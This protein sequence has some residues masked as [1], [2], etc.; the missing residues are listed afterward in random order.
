MG[1][2]VFAREVYV[3]IGETRMT[4]LKYNLPAS[5][6]SNR[7]EPAELKENSYSLLIQKQSGSGELPVKIE[8]KKPDGSVREIEDVLTGDKEFLP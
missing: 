4:T 1:K 3:P 7:G 6:Q 8:I 5:T 2:T